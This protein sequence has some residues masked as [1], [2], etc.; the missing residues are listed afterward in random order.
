MLST[1][2]KIAA[3]DTFRKN[4]SKLA[5]SRRRLAKNQIGSANRRKVKLKVAK[6][7]AE[8]AGTRWD[9]LRKLSTRLINANQV[10]TV[11]SLAVSNMQKNS[12]LP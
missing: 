6:L 11:E 1:G 8:V 2:E 7:Y 12:M 3:P 5:K 4:E 9:F 10:I